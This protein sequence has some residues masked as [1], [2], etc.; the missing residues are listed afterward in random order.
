MNWRKYAKIMWMHGMKDPNGQEFMYCVSD[1][2]D[3]GVFI[4][5]PHYNKSYKVKGY[6]LWFQNE[7]HISSGG[8]NF[9]LKI[10]KCSSFEE[11]M[12]LA[13]NIYD[14]F[15]AGVDIRTIGTQ[16]FDADTMLEGPF[17]N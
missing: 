10:K 4:I 8:D 11:G 12:R 3:K 14:D 2:I 5:L 13:E 9:G 16:Y 17:M 7:Q 6:S 15:R 1:P